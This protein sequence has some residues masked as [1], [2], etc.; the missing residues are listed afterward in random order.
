MH[1]TRKRARKGDG[2]RTRA[3]GNILRDAHRDSAVTAKAGGAEEE[4]HN[5][6]FTRVRLSAVPVGWNFWILE[7]GEEVREGNELRHGFQSLLSTL[8]YRSSE[9]IQT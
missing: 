2:A 3:V 7:K 4:T 6:K 9:N 5:G 8:M 1:R